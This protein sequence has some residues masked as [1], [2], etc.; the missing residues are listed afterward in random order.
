MK[1]VQSPVDVSSLVLKA[2]KRLRKHIRTT[3]LE[4]SPHLSE[5]SQSQVYL[6]LE[7][8]QFTHSFKLRGALNKLLSLTE[9]ERGKGVVTASSGNH[10]AGVA[11]ASKKLN[12]KG[13]I[14]LPQK[15]SSIKVEALRSYGAN[16]KFYGSD[17]VQTEEQARKQAQQNHQVFVSPYNDPQ[18]IGGQGTIGIELAQQCPQIDSVF[19]PVGGGGLISGIGGY[20]KSTHPS[21][22]VIGCQ[23][24][25]SPVMFESIRA[26][27]IVERETLPTLSDGSAGGIEKNSITFLLC[28]TYVDDFILVSEEEIKQ[29][30][31][32]SLEKQSLLI[33]GAAA[34]PIASFIKKRK[35][36]IGQNIILVI[37]GARISTDKLRDILCPSSG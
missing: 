25:N 15:T 19:V 32:L 29:A 8:F 36:Y 1:K 31:R 5:I 28:Q 18:I 35:E 33:E 30:I 14:Y 24:Q 2:E 7:N 4:Y 20:L 23:P 37:S 13:T 17:C 12:I 3:L 22:Q 26:G 34:L 9:D 16:L 6:K 10:G 21:I 11:F 27:K